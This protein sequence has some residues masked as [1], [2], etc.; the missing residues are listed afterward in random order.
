MQLHGNAFDNA[1]PIFVIKQL[2]DQLTDGSD[3]PIW[4]LQAMLE[5]LL[6]LVKGILGSL[7]CRAIFNPLIDYRVEIKRCSVDQAQPEQDL[8]R[9]IQRRLVVERELR[10]EYS[11]RVVQVCGLV[12]A[13]QLIRSVRG[14][15]DL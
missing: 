4:V 10:G 11:D 12:P 1:E 3:F 15:L 5:H 14:K 2:K 8:L 6:D 13:E 7:T 9:R